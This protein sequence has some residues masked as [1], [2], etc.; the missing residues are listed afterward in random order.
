MWR[1]GRVGLGRWHGPGLIVLPTSGGAWVNMRG[2]LWRVSNEQLRSA[3]S[4]EQAGIDLVNQYLGNMRDSLQTARVQRRYVD[5][6]REGTPRFEDDPPMEDEDDQALFDRDSDEENDPM[7]HEQNE[8]EMERSARPREGSSSEELPPAQRP[9]RQGTEQ[10]PQSEPSES[11]Q[12]LAVETA[13]PP[14][15]TSEPAYGPAGRPVVREPLMPYGINSVPSTSN[16]LEVALNA[17]CTSEHPDCL[18]Y[19]SP[20]PRDS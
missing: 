18:L 7:G 8:P 14:S 9:R 6:V 3:T 15:E 1:Q 11:S 19:T 4:D 2:A 16:H 12:R 20:S 10:E 17:Y 13:T 5:V